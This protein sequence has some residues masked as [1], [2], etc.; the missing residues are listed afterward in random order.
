MLEKSQK[1]NA[2]KLTNF[3]STNPPIRCI[4][5]K[6][7]DRFG[8]PT[9]DPLGIMSSLTGGESPMRMPPFLNQH[10]V[11]KGMLLLKFKIMIYLKFVYIT[12]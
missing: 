10:N 8:C 12:D 1:L 9:A 5:F 2:L 3:S 7:D 11:M 6:L 4:S